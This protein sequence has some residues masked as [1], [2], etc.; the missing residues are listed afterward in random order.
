[1]LDFMRW[2]MGD[3]AKEFRADVDKPPHM[4]LGERLQAEFAGLELTKDVYGKG[5]EEHGSPWKIT[6][7]RAADIGAWL[8]KQGY[9]PAG[10]N[11]WRRVALQ[12]DLGESK[13]TTY[14][15]ITDDN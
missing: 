7:E 3:R 2:F 12:V 8:R 6:G 14:I 5:P 11:K 10:K 15:Y 13:G 4:A 9:R 1:M